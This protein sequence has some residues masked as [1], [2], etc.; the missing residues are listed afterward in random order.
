MKYPVTAGSIIGKALDGLGLSG[1][2][3]RHR[4]LHQWAEIV[5]SVIAR[6]ARAVKVTGTV[7]HVVVD[8]SVWMNELAAAKGVLLQK[9][10]TSLPK[11]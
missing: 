8:S 7:L 11:G 4:V 6:H 3:A 2:V 1:I 10:N 9:L 5:D